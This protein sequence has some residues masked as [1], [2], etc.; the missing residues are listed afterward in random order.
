MQIATI[1]YNWYNGRGKVARIVKIGIF[2][3]LFMAIFSK[4]TKQRF[5]NFNFYFLLFPSM[6]DEKEH[7]ALATTEAVFKSLLRAYGSLKHIMEPYFATFG[8]SGSQWAVLI[9]LY[10]AKE[11]GLP[12]LR[13]RDIGER[14]IVR[15]PSVT[16]VVDRLQRLGL[17]AIQ[18]SATESLAKQV[19]LTS[20]GSE[21]IEHALDGHRTKAVAV[22]GDLSLEE[23][24][25]LHLM[26]EKISY[27]AK[28]MQKNK[29]VAE[30]H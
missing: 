29:K 3:S 13:L 21:L 12:S 17:G 5:A 18:T 26:L 6:A 7:A 4:L 1:K 2:L 15:P 8:I 10:R 16:S 22:F 23:Q 24:E 25:K 14:F 11:E 28:K 19:S 30:V 20:A 27:N 9:I